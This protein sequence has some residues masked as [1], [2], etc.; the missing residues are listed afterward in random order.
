MRP[1]SIIFAIVTI[2]LIASQLL[3][4][5]WLASKGAPAEGK[6]FHRKLGIGASTAALLTAGMTIVLASM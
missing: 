2:T 5:L 4:G 1:I 3:W 6:A